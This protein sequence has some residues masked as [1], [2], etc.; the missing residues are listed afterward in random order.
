[1]DVVVKRRF[2]SNSKLITSKV[3]KF[4]HKLPGYMS[5]HRLLTIIIEKEDGKK[6]VECFFVK[7]PL[8]VISNTFFKTE[9][10]FFHKKIRCFLNL[11]K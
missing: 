5:S 3:E 1:M 9:C 11:L 4:S 8:S 10:F 2:G 7:T 6:E